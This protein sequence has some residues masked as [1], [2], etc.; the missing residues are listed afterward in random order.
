MG[1]NTTKQAVIIS[2]ILISLALHGCTPYEDVHSIVTQSKFMVLNE[3]G[4]DL[5]VT[6]ERYP[7][8]MIDS[9]KFI[10]SGRS[11]LLCIRQETSLE[12]PFPTAVLTRIEAY[13][14]SAGTKKLVYI[15]KPIQND[16]W[17]CEKNSAL[18]STYILVL[19]AEDLIE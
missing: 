15:Q 2:G 12:H 19:H 8:I 1:I 14:D 3:T 5:W 18:S 17:M 4:S 13:K 6:N 9:M 16:A 11:L 10:A 7:P